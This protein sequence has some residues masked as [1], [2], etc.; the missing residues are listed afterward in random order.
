MFDFYKLFGLFTIIFAF[1]FI[2]VLGTDNVPPYVIYIGFPYAFIL[3]F[4]KRLEF[5]ADKVKNPLLW[6]GFLVFSG[7][8]LIEFLAYK[9]SGYL[10]A[11]GQ[12]PVVFCPDSLG[13]D[14]L[15]FGI[16]HYALIVYGFVWTLKRYDFS[17]FEFGLAIFLFWAVA[18][19]EFS[20]FIG[21]FVRGIPGIIGFVQAGLLLVFAFHGPYIIFEKRI[22]EML[23]ERS[24]SI[25]KY[26]PMILFQGASILLVFIIAIIRHLF[27]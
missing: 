22:R 5:L 14:L 18:V 2:I 7:G 10:V 1:F 3:F 6:F 12:N 25:K 9:T 15:L 20:H 17:V 26:V 19:D 13:C 23:P 24:T 4:H 21:L 27:N 11:Q 16:P 8:M